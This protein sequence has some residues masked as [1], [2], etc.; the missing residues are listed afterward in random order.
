[1]L[2]ATSNGELSG[3]L[4]AAALRQG[5]LQIHFSAEFYLK[6]GFMQV[7]INE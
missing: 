7:C 3:G 5:S 4:S 2:P 6:N 1:M